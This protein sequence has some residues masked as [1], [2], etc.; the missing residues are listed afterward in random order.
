MRLYIVRH[1]KAERDSDSGFDE[2]R[3]LRPRGERQA[4]WLAAGLA[5]AEPPPERILASEA[6]RALATARAIEATV[7]CPLELADE[8][9][10]AS[11]LDDALELIGS[12]F[13]DGVASLAVVGHNPQ[14]ADL[15]GWFTQGG[16]EDG[17]GPIHHVRTGECVALDLEGPGFE[18]ASLV[19]IWRLDEA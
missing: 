17:M 4:A 6:A 12:A 16:A 15:A 5:D 13:S 2:D 8:L 10:P 3:R 7:G 11:D 19:G 9:L 14:I 1:A 18:G